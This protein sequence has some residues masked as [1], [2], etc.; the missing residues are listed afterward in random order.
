MNDIKELLKTKKK[1]EKEKESL[2]ALFL[3]DEY[4][5]IQRALHKYDNLVEHEK[6][7]EK[8]INPVYELEYTN[9]LQQEISFDYDNQ[10]CTLYSSMDYE[11]ES[12]CYECDEINAVSGTME[13][14]KELTKKDIEEKL[15]IYQNLLALFDR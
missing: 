1:I 10:V 5:A 2:E 15:K 7:I 13:E 9:N 3:T 11:D 14:W 8:E 6:E 12:C 4:L